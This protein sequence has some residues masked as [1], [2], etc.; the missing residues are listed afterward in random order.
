ML[1][2]RWIEIVFRCLKLVILPFRK[3]SEEKT[4]IWFYRD[5]MNIAFTNPLFPRGWDAGLQGALVFESLL[6]GIA[7]KPGLEPGLGR[8]GLRYPVKFDCVTCEQEWNKKSVKRV[9]LRIT[10][11]LYITVAKL[12][13][14]P[15]STLFG[16][17]CWICWL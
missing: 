14:E 3:N 11:G 9:E 7:T 6:F 13:W 17:L 15:C 16:G 4:F 2:N 8:P 5:G 12:L 10:Q 1:L